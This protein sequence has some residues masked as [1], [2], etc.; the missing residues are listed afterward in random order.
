MKT[1]KVTK[2]IES[3][4]NV[5]KNVIKQSTEFHDYY[6]NKD[7]NLFQSQLPLLIQRS[8]IREALYDKN[9]NKVQDL[10]LLHKSIEEQD[11]NNDNNNTKNEEEEKNIYNKLSL[12]EIR[13]HQVRSK[14]LP[15]LCP[16]YNKK[17]ELLPE[18]VSTAKAFNNMEADSKFNLYKSTYDFFVLLPF[19]VAV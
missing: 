10:V 1:V 6:K 13:K 18:V 19:D 8:R 7:N 3:I 2:N 17:G 14:K 5:T 12:T 4:L 9:K 15:P 16:F 11:S